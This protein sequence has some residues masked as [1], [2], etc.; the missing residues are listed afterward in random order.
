MPKPSS[1]C[2]QVGAGNGRRYRDGLSDN[3]RLMRHIIQGTAPGRPLKSRWNE[4]SKYRITQAPTTSEESLFCQRWLEWGFLVVCQTSK[5]RPQ[6]TSPFR[7]FSLAADA[8]IIEAE[9]AIPEKH[10]A[11]KRG[12]TLF[13]HLIEALHFKGPNHPSDPVAIT[14]AM[15]FSYRE[16][17]PHVV[18]GYCSWPFFERWRVDLNY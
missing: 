15:R 13:R 9:Q 17:T 2:I 8:V 5:G 3:E 18:L 10:K 6:A 11:V 1:D 7:S 16:G 4:L 12:N 14:R